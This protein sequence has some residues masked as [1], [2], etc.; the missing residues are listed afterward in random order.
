[1]SIVHKNGYRRQKKWSHRNHEPSKIRAFVDIAIDDSSPI[2]RSQLMKHILKGMPDTICTA[3][4]PAYL[5]E[6]CM[7][8]GHTLVAGRLA[9]LDLHKNTPHTFREAMCLLL[10]PPKYATAHST[11]RST[12]TST[13]AWTL[14]TTS[15]PC[16]PSCAPTSCAPTTTSWSARSICARCA[17][18]AVS[19]ITKRKS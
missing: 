10:S 14:P 6:A 17:S 19:T 2:N 12:T 9:M 3:N 11:C 5:S 15:L 1:M 16:A 8:K 4:I 13:T 18:R 7:S